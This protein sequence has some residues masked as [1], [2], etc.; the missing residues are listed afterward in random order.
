LDNANL[1]EAGFWDAVLL[2]TSWE[3]AEATES[4]VEQ[5]GGGKR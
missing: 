4:L 1:Y 3:G 5:I 2:R